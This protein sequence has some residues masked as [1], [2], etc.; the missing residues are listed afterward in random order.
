MNKDQNSFF[1]KYGS[2]NEHEF[3]SVVVENFFER[4]AEL[5]EYNPKLYAL[6]AKIMRLNTLKPNAKII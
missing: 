6:T 1:R 5:Y 4:P 3:F 2:V